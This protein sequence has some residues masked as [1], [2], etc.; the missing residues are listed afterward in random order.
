MSHPQSRKR[1]CS[2]RSSR[3]SGRLILEFLEERSVPT[4]VTNLNDAGD[5]SL[6]QAILDTPSGGTVDFQAGLSGTITLTTGELAISK[7][8]TIAGPG[9][10]VITVSGSHASRVFE[11]D[12]SFTVDITGLTIADGSV[13]NGA[14]GGIYNNGTLILTSSTLSGNKADTNGG[15]IFNNQSGTLTV[16]NSI[17]SGNQAGAGGGIHNYYGTLTLTNST[18]SGN[19][20]S[21]YGL[22]AD[23]GGIDNFGGTLIV[24]ASTLSNNS[25]SAVGPKG[26][27]RG[28]GIYSFGTLNVTDS[29][30][31][32]NSAIAPGTGGFALGGGIFNDFGGTLN[33]T[34]CTLSDNSALETS[35]GIGEGGGILNTGPLTVSNSTL[36]GNS[37]VGGGR[38]Q[39]GGIDHVDGTLSVTNSTLSGN[40]ASSS[41]LAEGGGIYIGVELVFITRD[42][43]IA[44]NTAAGSPDLSGTVTSLGHNLIG[45]GTGGSGYDPTDLV[46]TAD[47]PIDPKLGPLQDNGGPTQTLSLLPGSPAIDAGDNADAPEWDQRG[48]GYPRIV[49]DII[50]IGAFEVQQITLSVTCSVANSLLWPPNHQLVNVGLQVDVQ[51]PDASLQVQVYANDNAN[52]SDAADIGPGTLELRAARQGNGSGR[53]YLIVA[54]ATSGGQTAFDVCTVVVPHDHS[55]GSIAKVQGEAANAEAYYRE[56]QTAPPG[57]VLL[58]EGPTVGDGNASPKRTVSV[59]GIGQPVSTSEG[60]PAVQGSAIAAPSTASVSPEVEPDQPTLA[61]TTPEFLPLWDARYAQDAVFGAW[62]MVLD[63]IAGN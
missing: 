27:A 42:T 12:A 37:I 61:E 45:D 50:D 13:N 47:N 17:F 20:A 53:V 14:G 34:N 49:N 21:G 15:G 29:T 36:S 54:T 56:F 52:T 4:T 24:T 32:G 38:A 31:S 9:A 26:I 3:H 2:G 23:A 10:S 6:R 39:G 62:D 41:S 7:S 1:R 58:G 11:I 5:G 22:N 43:I 59:I 51:P 55:A 16:T 63:G 40:T 57:Y 28:G 18:V 35:D 46:G 44:G 25:A 48:P 8:L 33:V 60:L 30:L 19:T